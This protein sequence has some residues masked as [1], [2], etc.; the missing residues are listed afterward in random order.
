[1]LLGRGAL[2]W[3]SRARGAVSAG[4]VV[5]RL[6]EP[7]VTSGTEIGV[8][9]N[10][11][12]ASALALPARGLS[13]FLY[14]PEV[15]QIILKNAR[16][17]ISFR[18]KK[19][20]RSLPAATALILIGCWAR[21]LL[22]HTRHGA[23]PRPL[24]AQQ[25]L[26]VRLGRSGPPDDF[27]LTIYTSR[28]RPHFRTIIYRPAINNPIPM[29]SRTLCLALAGFILFRKIISCGVSFAS[30]ISLHLFFGS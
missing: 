1:V 22:S 26:P 2:T 20:C 4:S 17:L 25:P 18:N 14:D 3:T 13:P 16:S 6:L 30:T 21:A 29:A 24:L 12:L 11:Q 23:R 15:A 5:A 27:R 9:L 7:H 10:I 19:D 28:N 8:V